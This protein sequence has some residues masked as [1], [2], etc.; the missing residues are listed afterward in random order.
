MKTIN[1]RV[2][3]YK[4]KCLTLGAIDS[5]IKDEMRSLAQLFNILLDLSPPFLSSQLT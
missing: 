4:A 3:I 1:L 2:I 5:A